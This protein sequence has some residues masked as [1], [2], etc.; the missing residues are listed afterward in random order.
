MFK[1]PHDTFHAEMRA[2]GSNQ[3]PG[4]NLEISKTKLTQ[5]LRK[6]K[7]KKDL[8]ALWDEMLADDVQYLYKTASIW[9]PMDKLINDAILN[10]RAS[11][12]GYGGGVKFPESMQR[13]GAPDKIEYSDRGIDNLG[14]GFQKGLE[15]GLFSL[16]GNY[17]PQ[18]NDKSINAKLKLNF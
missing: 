5:R 14:I 18:T 11:G 9:Q 15:N 4:E 7:T 12:F 17:N 3:F 6:V 8:D 1:T 2:Q 10:L 16:D 13:I